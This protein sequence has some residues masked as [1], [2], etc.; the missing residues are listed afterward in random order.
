MKINR[1]ILL[2]V[3]SATSI[4]GLTKP[5]AQAATYY[6]D[7]NGATAGFGTATGT[8]AAP[9]TN[10]AT[11][12][13]S[14]DAT[15][16][17][18]PS[19]TTTVATADSE[20][21][22]TATVGLA[23]GTVT[24]SGTV[25]PG[26]ITF[27][28]ASGAIILSGGTMNMG[29]SQIIVNNAS[30]TI[31]SVLGGANALTKAGT[32]TLI[33][34]GASTRTA[35]LT[36]SAGTLQV[37]NGG[38]TGSLTG[39]A[40]IANSGTL[41]Y[42]LSSNLTV[43]YVTSGAGALT[44]QGTGVLTL[45]G[46]NTYTGATNVNAG[47]LAFTGNRT[48]VMGG[49]VDVLGGGA[50]LNISGNLPMG[51]QQLRV[52]SGTTTTGT[53]NQTAGAVT[54]T[55][56]NQ[57]TVGTTSTSQGI[58]NL[59]GGTF[60]TGA[61]ANRGILVGTNASCDGIFNLSG[62][63]ALTVASGSSLHIGRSE[64]VAAIGAK[65]TF[66]Q[67]GGTATV[68]D[69]RMGGLSAATNANQVAAL[70]LS[71]GTFTVTSFTNLSGGDNSVSTINLSGTADVTLPAFPT[72]RGTGATA[73]IT[74]NGGTLRAAG[75][76]AAYL[77]GAATSAL[78]KAGGASFNVGTGNDITLTT[79]LLTD[80]VSLGGGLTKSGNGTL[81][82][83]GANTYTGSTTVNAGTLTLDYA[84][85]N[86][87]KLS[88][89]SA[90]VLSGGTLNL[91]GGSHTEV[92]ASTTLT[93][94]TISNVTSTAPGSVL[95]MGTITPN[96]GASVNF[97]ASNI[98][99]T[100]NTNTNGI[101]GYWATVGGSDW[102]VNSTNSVNGPIT[103]YTGYA[104]VPRLTPGIIVDGAA[105]F[106]RLIE[107]T[108]T[109]GS[110]TLGSAITTI[111]SLSQS[112]TGGS[113][114]ATID[115]AGQTLRANAILVA[116]G[117]GALT[118]GSGVNNGTLSAAAVGGDL[119]LVNSSTNALTIN[120]VI[121]DNTTA[122]T[123][124]T[125]GSG[126]TTLLGT[127]TYTGAT[128][129]ATGTLQIGNGGTT[130]SIASTSG[131]TNNAALIYNRSNALSVG[132]AISGTGSLTQ[133]GANTLTLT[134]T[135]TYTGATTIS[136]GTLQIGNGGTTGSIAN[137]SSLTNNAAF[138]YNR[139]D[140]LNVGYVISGTGSLTQL[141]AGTLNL[142]ATNTFTGPVAVTAGTLALSPPGVL[143]M[144]NLFTG[145][146]TINA[147]P[148]AAS[149]LTLSGDLS[150]FTGTINIATNT[151][152]A[153]LVLGATSPLGAGTVINIGTAATCYLAGGTQTGVIMNIFGTGNSENLGALRTDTATLDSTSSL[154]LRANGSVGGNGAANTGTIN[155]PISESGGS[156]SLTKQGGATTVL[157]GTNT[158][159]GGTIISAGVLRFKGNATLPAASQISLGSATLQYLDDG[160]GSNGTISRTGSGIT[161]SLASTTDTIDVGNN[162][163]ANT[164]NTVA[165]G[166]LNNG[167]PLNAFASTINFTGSNG[168]L[169]S[170]T[171]LGLTG[172]TG[173]NTTLNPTTTAVTIL[174]NVTN[175]ESGTLTAHFDTLTLGGTSIGNAINGVI[176]DAVGYVGPV[177][178]GDT[179]ITKSGTSTWTLAGP[180]T[181]SGVTTISA[182]VLRIANGLALGN[183]T[184]G[185]TVASGSTLEIDGTASPVLVG[186]EA[187]SI[188]GGGVTLPVANLGA[189]RNIAG[190]NNYS[191]TVTLTAQS[192]INSDSGTLTLDNPTA[193]T[194][195]FNLVVGGAGN[196]TIS[197]AIATTTGFVS[198]DGAGTVTLSG[199][200]TY[201]GA[202]SVSAGTLV[203]SGSPTGNSA[204]S[205]NGGTLQLDYSTNNT[206]KINDS[207]IL[208]LG[209]GTVDLTGGDHTE[210]V[211]STT[212]T[213][214]TAST[215]TRS[216]GNS[217]LQM[218]L[219]NRN[220]GASINFGAAGIAT[221]DTLNN[222][223][224]IIG[225]WATIGGTDWA[226][227]ST[228]GLGGLITAP[229]YV[230]V[231]RL[232]PGTIADSSLSNVR[233][234]EG[235]GAPG[236]I[237]LGAAT[238]TISTLNQS[239]TGGT[240]AAV[241]DPAGQ[242]LAANAILVGGGAGA[243]TIGTGTNNGTLRTATAGGDLVLTNST[244]NGLTIN[245]V[246]ADNT[247]ASTLTKLGTGTATLTSANTYT[248][249]T[250]VA[251]GTLVL[252]NAGAL[253]T[254]TLTLQGGGLDSSVAN[255]VNANNNLQAW[256]GNFA[257][258][259]TQNLDL[260]TG[261][262]TLS[263]TSQ[264]TVSANTLAVGGDVSGAF[265]VTKAGPG[266][267]LFSGVNTYTGATTVSAGTLTLSGARTAAATGGVNLGNVGGSTGTLNV[268]N[269]TFTVG[270]AGS[271]FLVGNA[272]GG[273]GILNQSGGSLT[274][275]GNQLLIGNNGGVG[276]YNLSGGTL[277]TIAGSLGVT[278]G[279]NTDST[280][281]FNLSG[282]GILSMPATSTLQ[283]TRSDNSAAS[284]VTGTFNQT[285]GTATVGILQMGGSNTT[286]ANNANAKAA[287][288]LSGGTFAATTF[289]QLS[290]ANTSV[291]VINISGT[292]DVTLP[293]FPTA[294]GTGATA[295]VT[296]DGGKLRSAAA[297]ATFMG[298]LTSAFIK[299]GGA[300]IEIA[301]GRDITITQALLADPV[302]TGGGLIK[303]GDPTIGTS[304]TLT[305][306]NTYT[307][308]TTINAGRISVSTAAP[309]S[310]GTITI[311]GNSTVGGQLFVSGTPTITNNFIISGV[312]FPDTVTTP[313]TGRGGAIRAGTGQTFSGMMTLAADSRFGVIAGI[314]AN[315]IN[316]QITGPF[317]MDFY[318]GLTANAATQTFTL[319][320]TGTPSDYSG[321]T[322]ITSIDFGAA[323]TGG[324]AILR[325]GA[326]EQV[327][328]GAGK[329]N[330]V[331]NGA[332]TD[333]QAI[334]ELNGFNETVNGVSN[335][336]ATGAIIR[337]TTVGAS[338]LT[339]GDADTT[340]SFS[341][342]VSDGGATATL[343]LNKIGTGTFTLTGANLYTGNTAVSAGTLDLAD[344]A[345]LKFVLGA[346]GVNNAIT[347]SGT[348]ILNGD[349]V[350]DTAAAD[351]LSFG[352]W[353]L[354]NVTSLPGAYGAT[355]SV[356]GFTD[357]GNNK[358]T[359]ANGAKTY[360]FDET[361]GILTLTQPGYT[362]WINSFFPGETNPLI[363]GAS[364]DPD[365]DGISNAVE[366]VLGGNP[367]TG[368]DSALL[369]TIELV[370]N[371]VSIPAIP[372]GNYILFT[373]RRTDLSVA[374]GVT[375]DCETDTDLLGT[376]TAATGAPGVI[377]QVDDN[378][379]SFIPPATAN[380]DRVR[381]YVPNGANS[382]IFGRLSVVVP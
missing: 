4:F 122:S 312:G 236:S 130:G 321:N 347:G 229:A 243:L 76:S 198:K 108:G 310:T 120:S 290:G 266:S 372:A 356:V 193:V 358:W 291:S 58:Y 277:T 92:V 91:S 71:G 380:T 186:A 13:W 18:L 235:S 138:V 201:T 115:P 262:V 70:N 190:N 324:K 15:G 241:I 25:T 63:G 381:V 337:N 1:Q 199:A 185:T 284:N 317:A 214:G 207:A 256:N 172:L 327:P 267:L 100:N 213:A 17:T 144:A 181:Y 176:S 79:P 230:D 196:I 335:V 105:S 40:S 153:K 39:T 113:S 296:F 187:L 51:A 194:G 141:G 161:L 366:M 292:A 96:A 246:I 61:Q 269:G 163:S 264:V 195:A 168:Y 245:S 32:G 75:P 332:D 134:N 300:N 74:F 345:Q 49:I 273:I 334:L 37:G 212:L 373:Y 341:G 23:A 98:A 220:A 306:A 261:A 34:T 318:G 294:R 286:P 361:T 173:G 170:Y 136:A 162:G 309:L 21:F 377:I 123:L 279:V 150:G 328:H 16:A 106:V 140:T 313:N 255:L 28:S 112:V 97:G 20:N 68:S 263:A 50:I 2:L 12:G 251:A 66:N 103:A 272:V 99:T 45:S 133:Q 167:T 353:T 118:I 223:N 340:S 81:M 233:I 119:T 78:I 62:S 44:K 67:T 331:F 258:V 3:A 365:G 184:S 308:G 278:V 200:N 307:G 359:K 217:V 274:T 234:I 363:I 86:N 109:A 43:S 305:G 254:G 368:M 8:W 182:G 339:I 85:Q 244:A 362:A 202:T 143:T 322:S 129:I 288:N 87:S 101:I 175:Q 116:T 349:F 218:G 88:D 36:I 147:N 203:I 38:A 191:G 124:T 314:T 275:I 295:T 77:G 104:D 158:Y 137:T 55:S 169:Q 350:I 174:G 80:G 315:T 226:V 146:G 205:V 231:P 111:N 285:G 211:A 126:T 139:T 330:L 155:A 102:A 316:G 289:N 333:H 227:N 360:T 131:V 83:S 311:N 132:Y 93:A 29:A 376:W 82:L 33:L 48:A 364:A 59:S 35:A 180:S 346:S 121:A 27:G 367:A 47:T 30:D 293:A 379:G 24:V 354:E 282:A 165:F 164:G 46:A 5:T 179:R 26:N 323:R 11:Q 329:G 64:A 31:S 210:F 166:A 338:T 114:A 221:T 110:I 369:P 260:G 344:N 160:A 209:G 237:L 156:F 374:G 53:I 215:V 60:T 301:S 325:L 222:A 135:N 52:G 257:F 72:T 265:G 224:G 54:F 197:G 57:L 343:G 145:T 382:R 177:G 351:A 242:T 302:S 208:T 127:N 252:G 240:S 19:G 95:Q 247:S 107:G 73:T 253:G 336:A 142:T 206:S 171:S 357:A 69:L 371:P 117:A 204:P 298:G 188:N 232:S 149:N 14:T 259:G 151:G 178:N 183:A 326:G 157:G 320:N 125:T 128:T 270:T 250:N 268:T 152:V 370:T 249:A 299:A 6:W 276:I 348:V 287:L 189:L 280:A 84:T 342:V 238:T 225:S 355:F 89:T 248:G 297:S 7:N 42:N 90:L 56:G 375:A 9:T 192:R 22:G 378:Y 271:N 10:N 41:I 154:I 94:N 239:A 304:L 319:A 219:I 303:S 65:G 281:T 216:A 148:A 283:I 228:N 159:T 352:S